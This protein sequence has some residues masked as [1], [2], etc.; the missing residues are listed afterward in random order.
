MIG[1]EEKIVVIQEESFQTSPKSTSEQGR[2]SSTKSPSMVLMK[3]DAEYYA[4]MV[5]R[6]VETVNS[7]VA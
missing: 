6:E 1:I 5:N 3:Q 4:K 7:R 2:L